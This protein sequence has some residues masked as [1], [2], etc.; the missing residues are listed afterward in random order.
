LLVLD[1]R[2]R[3]T[4]PEQVG[5]LY[6]AGTGLSPGYWRDPERTDQVF[7]ANP[8]SESPWKRLYKT[9]DLARVGADGLIN[10][11][12]R[13]DSQIKARG[14]RI[15][16]GEIET[17][18]HAV[19]GVQDAAVVA[20]EASAFEGVVICCAYVPS[21]GIELSPLA[22]K[23]DLARVLPHYMLPSRWLVLERMPLNGNGKTARP[24]L[25]EQFLEQ[26]PAG[27]TG[28]ISARGNQDLMVRR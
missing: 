7:V 12:G 13:S 21:P 24:H 9:G 8:D 22:L 1:D 16:L 19:P 28:R 18:V 20:V 10:L 5:D 15:E 23:K 6:I 17:A 11:L 3:P 27:L 14:Y 25:R 4:A 2:L 26:S